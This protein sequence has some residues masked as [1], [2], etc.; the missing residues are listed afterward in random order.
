MLFRATLSTFVLQNGLG[1][2]RRSLFSHYH[3]V[4]SF[5]LGVYVAVL[6]VLLHRRGYRRTAYVALAPLFVL[7]LGVPDLQVV[8]GWNGGSCGGQ[9]IQRKPWY[10]LTA[11]LTGTLGGWRVLAHLRR[12]RVRRQVRSNSPTPTIHD[13]TVSNTPPSEY[14]TLRERQ[15]RRSAESDTTSLTE[16]RE[17][18]SESISDGPDNDEGTIP[19]RCERL[20]RNRRRKRFEALMQQSSRSR[21]TEPETPGPSPSLPPDSDVSDDSEPSP[22]EQQ[23]TESPDTGGPMQRDESRYPIASD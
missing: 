11:L 3:E 9:A 13:T 10:F 2:Y 21:S 22:S 18:D 19:A 14:T 4:H 16:P 1:F 5:Q 15:Y 8:C 6:L 17:N 23:T 7:A 20:A 12:R